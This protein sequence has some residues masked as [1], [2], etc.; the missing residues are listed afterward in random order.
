M[1]YIINS[2]CFDGMCL[3][4][5]SDDRHSDYGGETLEEL[6]DKDKNPYLVAVSPKQI[7]LLLKR[8]IRTLCK[9]F[10][11]I[12][13]ERYYDL[14]NSLLPV[15]M[16]SGWFFVGKPYYGNF[17]LFCFRS[18]DRFFKGVRS[19]RLTDLEISNQIKEHMKIVNLHPVLVKK[20]S[21]IKYVRWYNKMVTYVPYCFEYDGKRY[22]LENL[23]TRTGTESGDRES[24][25]KMANRLASLRR[26]HYQYCTFYAIKEDIFE[27]FKWLRENN[28]HWKYV[29]HYLHLTL[30][31]A[32]WTF[33]AM[34]TN[35]L[36]C[37]NTAFIPVKFCGILLTSFVL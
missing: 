27:F 31:R 16:K 28:T 12:T 23:A 6:R 7:D 14:L 20:D 1:K 18:G 21:F 30:I 9:P 4:A 24:R 22:F 36:R 34:Y 33:G 2:R 35:I 19:L 29:A 32:M 3:T 8:Y 17:Y 11:E 13:E 5:M 37:S 25:R 26:H 10:L 15:R